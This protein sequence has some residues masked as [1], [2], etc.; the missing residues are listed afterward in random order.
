MMNEKDTAEMEAVKPAEVQVQLTL[1]ANIQHA[2][3][4][5]VKASITGVVTFSPDIEDIGA[6]LRKALHQ[7]I[8]LLAAELHPTKVRNEAENLEALPY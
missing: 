8:V 6:D 7:Q 3:Y 5:T 1:E 4:S 2:P